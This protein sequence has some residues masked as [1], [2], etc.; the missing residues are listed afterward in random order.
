MSA[1]A[2]PFAFVEPG[3][4]CRA[5]L[6]RADHLRGDTSAL[7]A[8]WARARVLLLDADGRALADQDG[9]LCAPTGRTLSDGP[10]GVGAAVFLGLDDAGQGWFVLEAALCSFEAPGRVDLRTAAAQWSTL[11]ASVFA[12]ARALQHWRSRHRYC[13]SC[14]GEV[15]LARGG[16]QGTCTRCAAAHYPRT[17]PAVIVAVSDGPRLLLGRQSTWPARRY[18]VIAGFVEPGESLEQTVAREVMEEAGV[19]VRSCRYL[20]SQPWP[21]P[22]ALMLGFIAQAHADEPRVGDE[23]EDARWFSAPEIRAAKARE[24]SLGNA[25]GQGER[26]SA[27]ANGLN[28]TTRGNTEQNDG[29]G[30]DGGP[31]LSAP[32]SIARWLIEH[33]LALADASVAR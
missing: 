5:A 24:I 12:Q 23:L 17:D 14:G 18:S 25:A 1:A 31:L 29:A 32:M 22:G 3:D 9:R 33:W 27:G 13:G 20:A 7:A 15:A 10:G 16:W 21:F 26:P 28:A 6:D 4:A 11:E 8:L 30:D 19:R 2:P